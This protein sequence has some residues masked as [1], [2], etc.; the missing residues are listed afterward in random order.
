M[1]RNMTT[2]G[3]ITIV[4]SSSSMA[5]LLASIPEW[6]QWFLQ[7]ALVVREAAYDC[8]AESV[9][10][11]DDPAM[12][13]INAPFTRKVL[14]PSASSSASDARS[15]SDLES[16]SASTFILPGTHFAVNMKRVI[17]RRRRSRRGLSSLSSEYSLRI[18]ISGRWSVTRSN[19]GNSSRNGL[20]FFMAHAAARPSSSIIAFLD[21]ADERKRDPA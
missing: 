5:L 8:L 21:S 15:I 4:P 3:P 11:L 13:P 20:H 9:D 10:W 1:E 16:A 19:A 7:V 2:R 14:G 18:G 6:A 12:S 17:C